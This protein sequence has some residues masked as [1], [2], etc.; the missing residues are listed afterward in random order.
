MLTPRTK[1][2][3][4]L[5]KG[6][7]TR[8]EWN[9]LLRLLNIMTFSMFSCS[10]FLSNTKQS[11]YKTAQESK[12]EEGLAVAKPRP[13]CF[14]NTTPHTSYFL[15][16]SH[17]DAWLKSCVYRAR[18]MCHL[19]MFVLTLFDYS[20]FLSLLTIFSPIVLFFLLAISFFFHDVVDKFS[21]CTPLM[22]TLAPLPSTTLS[23]V[24]EP[25]DYHITEATEPYIQESSVENGSPNDFEYDDVT[26]GKALSSPRSPRSEK[27]MRAVDEPIT[28]KTKFCCRVCRR[29][30][31]KIER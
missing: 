25:N 31:V 7:F 11:V 18:I 17:A 8:D 4:V 13:A 2:G 5:T 22:R 15:T 28:L 14:V 6:G 9:H 16:D 26:I 29:P 23:Q 24:N 27:M 19:H 3:A 10:H 21:C 30:S 12:T 20:T 1:F